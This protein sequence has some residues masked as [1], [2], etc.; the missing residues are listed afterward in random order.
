MGAERFHRSK[1]STTPAPYEPIGC[2]PGLRADVE[3][4]GAEM[5]SH[6]DCDRIENEQRWAALVIGAITLIGLVQVVAACLS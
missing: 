3:L 6:R 4:R 2:A 5:D 1:A